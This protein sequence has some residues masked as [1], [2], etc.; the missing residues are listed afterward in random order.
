MKSGAHARTARTTRTS[1]PRTWNLEPGTLCGAWCRTLQRRFDMPRRPSV[2]LLS[3]VVHVLVLIVLA[4][5]D[6][7]RPITEWPTPRTALA[8][9]EDTPRVVRL[10]D[11]PLPPQPRRATTMTR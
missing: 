7:W 8:F 10:D 6:L 9:L 2:L 4:S 5:A 11:V 1:E 3:I